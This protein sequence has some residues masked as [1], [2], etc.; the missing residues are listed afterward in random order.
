MST[1]STS[2]RVYG[3]LLF[4]LFEVIVFFGLQYLLSDMG[5]SNQIQAENTIVPNWVKAVLFILLYILCILVAVM[6]VSN[7]VPGKHR[8]QLSRWVYLAL[9][10]LVPMLFLLFN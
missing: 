2:S 10:A 3:L 9:L 8:K 7:F 4:L 5:M 6:L 1:N